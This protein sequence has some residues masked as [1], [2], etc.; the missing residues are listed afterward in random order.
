MQW[1]NDWY[2]TNK[3][4]VQ[5]AK[6]NF[7]YFC[8]NSSLYIECIYKLSVLYNARRYTNEVVD[9]CVYNPNCADM[10]LIAACGRSPRTECNANFL[11]AGSALSWQALILCLHYYRI[12][13]SPRK[14]A[15]DHR[16]WTRA[17]PYF[18][19]SAKSGMQAPT[20]Y[21]ITS[22]HWR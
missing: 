4:W 22:I 12:V 21:S 16:K 11:M 6:L 13:K 20:C 15:S 5:N 7:C 17:R 10:L 14:Y 3:A 18:L 19:L 9:W 1:L 2:F 8:H